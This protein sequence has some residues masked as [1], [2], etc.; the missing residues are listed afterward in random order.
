MTTNGHSRRSLIGRG[1][2]GLAAALGLGAGAGA[3]IT[4]ARTSGDSER[5]H[6]RFGS[7]VVAGR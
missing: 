1:F 5:V 6:K 7:T 4:A 3:G 2:V